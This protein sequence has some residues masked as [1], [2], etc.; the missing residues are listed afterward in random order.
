MAPRERD[1][2]PLDRAADDRVD[3]QPD[4]ELVLPT[5]PILAIVRHSEPPERAPGDLEPYVIRTENQH[6]AMWL[7]TSDVVAFG[8]VDIPQRFRTWSENWQR[9]WS[10]DPSVN[11]E[12]LADGCDAMSEPAVEHVTA[13]RFVRD[14]TEE[15]EVEL[16]GSDLAALA[17]ALNALG[18]EIRRRDLRGVGIVDASD[19]PRRS[20]LACVWP[21]F[22][23][24]TVVAA[25]RHLRVSVHGDRGML[26]AALVAGDVSEEVAP[27]GQV[28]FDDLISITGPN[29][30]EPLVRAPDRAR[31]LAWIAPGASR[32]RA[33]AVPEVLAY[34]RTLAGL[35]EAAQYARALRLPVCFTTAPPILDRDALVGDDA[36]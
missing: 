34:A 14:L 21:H 23:R 12:C 10:L 3:P 28:D 2:H 13:S 17:R 20:G 31:P 32:W 18:D 1:R 15:G 27:V 26:L 6:G 8:D 24:P 35:G 4:D 5:A 36:S 29:R 33:R 11:L 16:A 19:R 9:T 22:V 7:L 25:D 30:V